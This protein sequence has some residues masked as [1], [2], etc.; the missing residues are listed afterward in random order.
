MLL[1]NVDGVFLDHTPIPSTA[2][3]T[4]KHVVLTAVRC[5]VG[6]M[7]TLKTGYWCIRPTLCCRLD[8]NQQVR[9]A[10]FVGWMGIFRRSDGHFAIGRMDTLRRSDGHFSQVGWAFFEVGVAFFVVRMGIFCRSAQTYGHSARHPSLSQL[11]RSA[12]K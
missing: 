7:G 1:E 10:F 4:Y 3:P 11:Q 5:T 6:R 2:H 9:W 12:Q 8:T